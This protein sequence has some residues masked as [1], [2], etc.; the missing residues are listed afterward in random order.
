MELAGLVLIFFDVERLG[1][2][3]H[4][5]AR[6]S[7]NF[8]CTTTVDLAAAFI[9]IEYLIWRTPRVWRY[10]FIDFLIKCVDL[11]VRLDQRIV[12]IRLIS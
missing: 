11:C 10:N 12:C 9:N 4:A 8:R 6:H 2:A 7:V 5:S 3:L 1:S